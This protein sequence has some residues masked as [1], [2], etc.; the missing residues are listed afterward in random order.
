V[1]NKLGEVLGLTHILL[2]DFSKG[3]STKR[4]IYRDSETIRLIEVNTG[5]I[6]QSVQVALGEFRL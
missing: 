2:V 5:K 4:N 3:H 1:K 6:I